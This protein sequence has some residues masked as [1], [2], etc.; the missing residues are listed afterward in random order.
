MPRRP[1][2]DGVKF[3]HGNE[4]IWLADFVDKKFIEI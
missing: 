4:T 1:G 3:Y 2:I